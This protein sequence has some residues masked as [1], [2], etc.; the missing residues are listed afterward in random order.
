MKKENLDLSKRLVEVNV[1]KDNS[2][3]LEI[4]QKLEKMITELESK[5]LELENQL[6][7]SQ[8]EEMVAK[9]EKPCS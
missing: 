6:A 7:F 9:I 4:N 1:I 3:H 8:K 5:K 2:I